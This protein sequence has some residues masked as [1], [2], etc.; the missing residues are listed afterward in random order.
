MER[1]R[2]LLLKLLIIILILSVVLFLIYKNSHTAN[3]DNSGAN[4]LMQNER[5]PAGDF[6]LA[7]SPPMPAI[8]NDDPS[9]ESVNIRILPIDG[10]KDTVNL[11][12]IDIGYDGNSVTGQ[13]LL[14]AKLSLNSIDYTN[15]GRGTILSITPANYLAEGRYVISIIAS[16]QN[17]KKDFFIPVIVG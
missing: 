7:Y 17:G 6:T 11:K 14:D 13:N 4:S 3:I 9:V 8:D 12:V 1:L 16:T 2:Y 10:F 5:A 15:F